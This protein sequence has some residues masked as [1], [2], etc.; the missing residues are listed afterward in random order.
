MATPREVADFIDKQW[1]PAMSD[2]PEDIRDRSAAEAVRRAARTL[3]EAVACAKLRG[4][5]VALNLG[6]L[7]HCS[8]DPCSTTVVAVTRAWLV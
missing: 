6:G 3:H 5:D 4:L 2:H 7:G 1:A 8:F